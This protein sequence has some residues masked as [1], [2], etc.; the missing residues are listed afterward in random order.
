MTLAHARALCTAG[1]HADCLVFDEDI[2][3]DRLGLRRLAAWLLCHAPA[4]GL[5]EPDGLLADLTGCD[6]L[7][8]QKHGGEYGFL[9]D[10]QRRLRRGG[11]TARLAIAGT[12]GAAWGVARYARASSDAGS[13]ADPFDRAAQ[14]SDL[15][16]VPVGGER[17]ALAPLPI[18]ALRCTDADVA[19]LKEVHVERVHQFL[20]LDRAELAERFPRWGHDA[21]RRPVAR[22]HRLDARGDEPQ[23]GSGNETNGARSDV[24]TGRRRARANASRRT[25][26]SH[27]KRDASRAPLDGGIESGTGDVLVGDLRSGERSGGGRIR[28]HDGSHGRN[29]DAFDPLCR[30]DQAIGVLPELLQAVRIAPSC[31]VER[32][33]DGPVVQLEVLEIVVAELVQRL[34]RRLRRRERGARSLRLEV[35]RSDAP[36]IAIDL[37]LGQPTRRRGHLWSLV[38]PHIETLPIGFGVDSLV[39]SAPRVARMVHR[40][41]GEGSA[42]PAG[43]Q[44][45]HAGRP[46][47]RLSPRPPNRREPLDPSVDECLDILVA[48]FGPAA[49]LRASPMRTHEPEGF[50]RL[51]SVLVAEPEPI[52]PR[53]QTRCVT[54]PRGHAGRGRGGSDDAAVRVA[55]A[56]DSNVGRLPVPELSP[57]VMPAADRPTVLWTEPEP[58]DVELTAACDPAAADPS[59][60]IPIAVRWRGE[61]HVVVAV[62]GHERIDD[63]WWIGAASPLIPARPA[64]PA[65]RR[66]PGDGSAARQR[67]ADALSEAERAIAKAMEL[68]VAS[69]TRSYWRVL[70]GS[71]LWLWIRRDSP[72]RVSAAASNQSIDASASDKWFAHGAWA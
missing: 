41:L 8:A 11:L 62:G 6:T 5:D 57:D 65:S 54:R 58:I 51:T 50:A 17:D 34:C 42:A 12:I 52:A 18:E 27:A 30:L 59:S 53:S 61:R 13:R 60:V 36:P 39:L 7:F 15:F 37:H 16:V 25:G 24:A 4:V 31:R 46:A 64:T 71:G 33:F 22:G 10:L 67:R 55:D 26:G 47:P 66:P 2:A 35:R 9:V 38:Q 32:V 44:C 49:V 69:R 14:S 40:Q 68:V 43:P 45:D 70:L 29:D 3:G 63:R 19:A 28:P 48:R 72:H 21:D 20:E 1:G 56:S 23:A